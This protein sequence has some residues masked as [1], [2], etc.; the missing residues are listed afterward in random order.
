MPRAWRQAWRQAWP[1]SWQAAGAACAAAPAALGATRGPR[2]S[3]R[4]EDLTTASSPQLLAENARLKRRLEQLEA[5]QR[6][7]GLLVAPPIYRIVLTGG[8]CAGKTSALAVMRERLEVAGWRVFNVPEAATLLFHNGA[9][10]HDFA[11]KGEVGI[12]EFQA[13][14][15]QLQMKLEKTFHE[16]AVVGGERAVL[17]C[18]RGM[19]DGK[20]YC[21]PESWPFVLNAIGSSEAHLRDRHYDAVIHLVTAAR[22]AEEFYTL[23]QAEG[24]P[25]SAS[26]RTESAEEARAQD[27]R[28]MKAWVGH[29][30][31][32]VI[33]NSTS[34]Q[35]KMQRAADRIF[36]VIGEPVAGHM[37]RKVRLPYASSSE[38]VRAAASAGVSDVLLFK[39]ETTYVS[40]TSRVRLRSALDGRGATFVHQTFS[41]ED[42]H[43]IAECRLDGRAYMRRMKDAQAD[44]YHTV[45][46]ELVCFHW[47]GVIYEVNVFSW[48]EKA[49]ILEVEAESMDTPILVPP[50]L[51]GAE[52]DAQEVTLDKEYDTKAIAERHSKRS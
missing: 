43:Q 22:G 9:R 47:T 30:H 8:P 15:A 38:I 48:P 32:Y 49:C 29:E 23:A 12:V 11:R 42:G 28:T 33:D 37:L 45:L 40:P 44:G 25:A 6:A 41:E 5:A 51:P 31:F 46:K 10:F 19:Q 16:M 13:A 1:R 21:A 3:H 18:D 14:L 36:K 7:S 52:A 2:S 27:E 39:C 50:F 24:G 34:F 20:A 26:A 17:L 35:Q 4:C